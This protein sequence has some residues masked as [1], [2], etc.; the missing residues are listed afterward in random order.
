MKNTIPVFALK[1][2]PVYRIGMEDFEHLRELRDRNGLTQKDLARLAGTTQPQINRLETGERPLTP[3]WAK[4]LAPHLGTTPVEIIFPEMSKKPL[5]LPIVG[6]VGASTD[7]EVLQESDHGPFGEITAPLGAKGTEAVVE[8]GGHSM[9]IY[10]PDGSLILYDNRHDPP[11]ENML[12][13]VCV[14]GLPDGRVLVKRL[15]RGSRRGLF[16]LESV[17][18]E[19]M[20]DQIVDW[21]AV[22]LVVVHPKQAKRLR[23]S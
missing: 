2:R 21:A 18:G 4:R 8:V 12:G 20:R 5:T 13:E 15:L 7:G 17:V 3:Q 16:D 10:A 14:V 9:G 23:V 1:R 19:T 22:V 6:R 11:Q